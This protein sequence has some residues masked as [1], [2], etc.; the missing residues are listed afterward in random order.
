MLLVAG[1]RLPAASCRCRRPFANLLLTLLTTWP[2]ARLAAAV[3]LRPETGLEAWPG[4][5]GTGTASAWQ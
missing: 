4:L 2:V 1:C 5:N 3:E